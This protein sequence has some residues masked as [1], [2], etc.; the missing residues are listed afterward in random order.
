MGMR[1]LRDAAARMRAEGFWDWA[2]RVEEADAL[3]DERDCSEA[4]LVLLST[5]RG[6]QDGICELGNSLRPDAAQFAMH[7]LKGVRTCIDQL[8]NA[9]WAHDENGDGE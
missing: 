2:C 3:I 7:T 6:F 4:C 1:P 5:M 9:R 8:Q